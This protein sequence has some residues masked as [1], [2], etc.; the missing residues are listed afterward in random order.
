LIKT[1]ENVS[2][3]ISGNLWNFQSW[4]SYWLF[5]QADVGSV[6]CRSHTRAY[7]HVRCNRTH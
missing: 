5:L 4:N 1:V 3:K 2:C 6:K 7:A